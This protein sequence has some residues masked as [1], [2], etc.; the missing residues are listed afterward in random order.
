MFRVDM[1]AKDS[2]YHRSDILGSRIQFA[3]LLSVEI[4]ILVVE[5]IENL[6]P[7]DVAEHFH[8]HDVTCFGIRNTTYTHY[9]IVIVAVK[10]RIAA[11][12]ENL[13]VAF[14][15]PGRIV[16]PVCCVEMLFSENC[17]LHNR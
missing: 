16:Q 6:I 7:D 9:E 8:I 10:I 4:Q 12:A 13:A 14:V 5:A 3:K 11:F 17:Y 15:R 2:I 1:I